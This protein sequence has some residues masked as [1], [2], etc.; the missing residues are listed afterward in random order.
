MGRFSQAIA[1]GDGISIV[2]VLE[3]DV[4]A[5]ASLA[6][7]AGAEA[8]AVAARDAVEVRMLTALPMVVE[9]VGESD[10]DRV[11]QARADGCTVVF[12]PDAGEGELFDELFS[13]IQGLDLDC[14]VEVRDEDALTEVLERVDPEIL[15]I[16]SPRLD[17]EDELE[18]VLDLLPD[19]PAGKL[20]IARPRL[21]IVRE[22]VV[23][24]ER[25]GVDAVLVGAEVLRAPDFSAALA[26]LTGR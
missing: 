25:A 16:A 14:A 15:I 3:S 11:V 24:L 8:V 9:N 1:E 20:V 21:P 10:L 5:V 2:P 22:Q 7:E 6:E 19:V 13:A 4:A 26:Q 18:H 23:A 17:D 12:D